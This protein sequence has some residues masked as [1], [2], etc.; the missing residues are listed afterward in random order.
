MEFCGGTLRTR[1][2]RT[3][4][5]NSPVTVVHTVAGSGKTT[6]IRNLLI[7]HPQ[8]VARTYGTPDVPNLLGYGIRDRHGDAHIVDE[9][10]AADLRSHPSVS[11]V[12]ADPLQH[13]GEVKPAHFTCSHTHRF[14]KSTCSLLGTLGVHCTSD[15]EDSVTFAEA[16]LAEPVGTFIALGEDAELVLDNH[17]VEYFT[18]CQALGLTFPSVTLLTDAPIE[19]Q[20]PVSRYIALTRHTDSLLILS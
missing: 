19:D 18:P 8:L 6:F 4:V 10:P 1:F 11:I 9:Y 5:P 16:Y 14:G 17:R 3:S 12:F 7:D 13:H 20:P 2:Q 15:K